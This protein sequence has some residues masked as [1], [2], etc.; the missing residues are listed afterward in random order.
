[1]M[2]APF[3]KSIRTPHAHPLAAANWDQKP[4]GQAKSARGR[5]RYADKGTSRLDSP[6]LIDKEDEPNF[7]NDS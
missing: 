7:A 4:C 2:P 3:V 1:M 5:T 6:I